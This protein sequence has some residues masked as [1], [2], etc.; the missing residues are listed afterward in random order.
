MGS[1]AFA[2]LLALVLVSSTLSVAS[3][4]AS[5]S[6]AESD[7]LGFDTSL[8]SNFLAADH[9]PELG[10]IACGYFEGNVERGTVRT[11]EGGWDL[12]V[13]W[14][15]PSGEELLWTAG[16]SGNELCWDITWASNGDFSL[17]GSFNGTLNFGERSVTSEG[18]LDGFLATYN[19]SIGA[20][21]HLVGIGGTGDDGLRG[22]SS[23]G[24]GSYVV[25]GQVRSTMQNDDQ[26]LSCVTVQCGVAARV[27]EGDLA[28]VTSMHA[29]VSATLVDV[30]AIEG[31][32][33][34]L[35]LGEHVGSL[36][37]PG[38]SGP[39]TAQ[40]NVETVVAR[41]TNEGD[42]VFLDQFQSNGS[43]RP[44]GITRI[45][46]GAAVLGATTSIEG[47]QASVVRSNGWTAP[48]G[49]GGADLFVLRT[50]TT[51]L[52]L[53]GVLFGS[54]EDDEAGAIDSA[55]GSHLLIG[56]GLGAGILDPATNT[57][58]GGLQSKAGFVA[59]LDLEMQEIVHRVV[60]TEGSPSS[61]SRIN[62]VAA[63]ARDEAWI[64]GRMTEGTPT[65][66]ASFL[67]HTVTA[68]SLGGFLA[69]IGA[70]YD[71]DG[72]PSHVDNCP[73]VGNAD[74][75][76]LDGDEAGDACDTDDDGDGALDDVDACPLGQPGNASDPAQDHDGDGCLNAEDADD[77]ND[78]HPDDFDQCPLGMVG[79]TSNATSD[80]DDDGCADLG[81]D[82]D[83]DDDRVADN[84]DRCPRGATSWNGLDPALDWDADGC[85]DALE[86]V[87]DDDDGVYDAIDACDP[88]SGVP[89]VVGW[90]PSSLSD[91]DGDGCQDEG[92]ANSGLGEDIDDDD[93]GM[94]DAQD[95][96]PRT[97]FGLERIDFD[98]D[99]CVDAEDDDDDN[100]GVLDID[101]ACPQTSS[102]LL[103]EADMDGDG[104]TST[105]DDDD[106]NDGIIDQL[107]VQCPN[108]PV[109]D[110][111]E[112]DHDQ[113]GC[114]DESEDFDDDGDGIPDD[115]D[116]CDPDG[117]HAWLEA[118][119]WWTSTSSGVS[120]TDHDADGCKDEGP[121]NGGF[122]EDQDDDNDGVLDR[123]DTDPYFLTDCRLS[124]MS[125]AR[126]DEDGDG[127][128][129]AA[130]VDAD[131]DGVEDEVQLQRFW[132]RTVLVALALLVVLFVFGRK[133]NTTTVQG[134]LINAVNSNV[135]T[136]SG[137]Q[138]V[139]TMTGDGEPSMSDGRVHAAMQS[140][141]I[142]AEP[143][144]DAW[145]YIVRKVPPSTDVETVQ[146]WLDDRPD[147]RLIAFDAMGRTNTWNQ[148]EPLLSALKRGWDGEGS[149]LAP[150]ADVSVALR[151]VWTSEGRALNLFSASARLTVQDHRALHDKA[152][153]DEEGVRASSIMELLLAGCAVRTSDE[154]SVLDHVRRRG[155]ALMEEGV[156]RLVAGSED[157]S[158]RCIDL[159]DGP[160]PFHDAL[161]LDNA[162][163]DLP[164][165][166]VARNA[167]LGGVAEVDCLV[168]LE[169]ATLE[170]IASATLFIV[171]GATVEATSLGD[172]RY[173]HEGTA[174]FSEE[175]HRRL[176]D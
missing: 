105:E 172:V 36:T 165:I 159:I 98:H 93:D 139:V 146:R 8:T 88:D 34:S 51:G 125:P 102:L 107:D 4:E 55:S 77:D 100:D 155:E 117:P 108:S 103:E 65:S 174:E 97:A 9:D 175:L 74:Q 101:D 64:G 142:E 128:M 149:Y 161:H 24:N 94:V 121:Q 126:A 86:D 171:K 84:I 127:C 114:L 148:D 162:M 112:S 166:I 40:G 39:F 80:W 151:D 137:N 154:S 63:L 16:S 106:D 38:L 92:P 53:D 7:F 14:R 68:G 85:H 83:D 2:A 76:D 168:V 110:A 156:L 133:A 11:S 49:A 57:T 37:V 79:W 18:G 12:L 66:G 99:G 33:H 41:L 136:G 73:S 30:L 160:F 135:A 153:R 104:C 118:V 27:D 21:T 81:E 13:F 44:R 95:T 87:D 26:N 163:S 31:S 169:H 124:S 48:I 69:H 58:V 35:V 67:G 147:L 60:T 109:N 176:G 82:E 145:P 71:A 144:S 25:V 78:T 123:D 96:C 120:P 56:G 17:V 75:S 32:T 72:V 140:P 54:S 22:V 28:W 62:A 29:A 130:D 132:V 129:D 143:A 89:S 91:A 134:D 61:D 115:L 6:F 50:S 150:A 158:Y 1:K 20:W 90:V 152:R 45:A 131:G 47:D 3:G 59:H 164:D 167:R 138:T 157:A 170:G 42:W 23:L 15:T 46:G 5:P 119:T 173:I 10:L 111:T 19:T 52:I 122:G 141:P 43:D 70:D 116:Q 113:D